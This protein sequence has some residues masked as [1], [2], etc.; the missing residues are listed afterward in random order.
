MGMPGPQKIGRYGDDFKLKAV[1]MSQQPNV[2]VK[3]VAESLCIHPFLLSKWRKMVRDGILVGKPPPIEPAAVA[4]LQRLREVELQFKRL[5][6][7]HD[8][9]K[10]AIRFVSARKASASLSSRQTGKPGPSR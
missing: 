2:L 7:E 4:E 6:M 8:L 10:K 5:Q 1:F 3:D 9:L